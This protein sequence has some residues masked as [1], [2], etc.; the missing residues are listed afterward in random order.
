MREP[1][2]ES[3]LIRPA[4][5]CIARLGSA[6][7][8]DLIE[9]LTASMSPEGHDAEIID[10]RNDTFF[11]QKVR[12]LVSHRETNGMDVLT[13]F[14]DGIYTLTDAGR[15]FLEDGPEDD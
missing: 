9:E 1:Y 13:D 12:N 11:S 10:N 8:T 15:S 6:T 3:E 2:T 7:T 4:L 5:E 14:E